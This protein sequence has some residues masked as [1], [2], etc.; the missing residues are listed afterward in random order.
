MCFITVLIGNHPGGQPKC[1]GYHR[2]WVL[3]AMGYDSLDCILQVRKTM[4]ASLLNR[5]FCSSKSESNSSS[6]ACTPLVSSADAVLCMTNLRSLCL[7][8]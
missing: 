2:L 8:T 3:R 5:V 6:L 7:S 1:M 4:F